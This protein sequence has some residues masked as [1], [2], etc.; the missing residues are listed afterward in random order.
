MKTDLIL[1]VCVLSAFSFGKSYIIHQIY[2]HK[3]K[4]VRYGCDATNT[5]CWYDNSRCRSVLNKVMTMMIM[6]IMFTVFV[7]KCEAG[8]SSKLYYDSVEKTTV[9][10]SCYQPSKVT[11]YEPRDT[12]S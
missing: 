8:Y 4:T 1:C 7:L 6:M 10:L 11:T 12:A 3:Y 2:N 9:L 5:S